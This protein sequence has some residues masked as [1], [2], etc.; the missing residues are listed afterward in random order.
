MHT[1]SLHRII[2]QSVLYNTH[3]TFI[4]DSY[5][6]SNAFM[7]YSINICWIHGKKSI[8]RH[9]LADKVHEVPVSKKYGNCYLCRRKKKGN[10]Q[11]TQ[12][13][14]SFYKVNCCTRH[15][16]VSL[17]LGSSS[18]Q[19]VPGVRSLARVRA[20]IPLSQRSRGV[21]ASKIPREKYQYFLRIDN[22]L[23]QS[24]TIKYIEGSRFGKYCA[25]TYVQSVCRGAMEREILYGRILYAE[26]RVCSRSRLPHGLGRSE[27]EPT[28][29]DAGNF[30]TGLLRPTCLETRHAAR[31]I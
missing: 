7:N 27:T 15:N 3:N 1:L 16:D 23:A 6:C 14:F 19:P 4:N 31:N 20:N 5:K 28:E 21:L 25:T 9:D 26:H 8:Q 10:V 30:A 22:R 2:F 29:R 11:R 18:K 13:T 24:A 17:S 12:I